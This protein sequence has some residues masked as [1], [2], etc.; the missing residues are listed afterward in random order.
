MMICQAGKEISTDHKC[1]HCGAEPGPNSH[2]RGEKKRTAWE[3]ERKELI[4]QLTQAR[5]EL[6]RYK[7]REATMGWADV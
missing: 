7:E 5:R 3:Q 6:A 2:C 4:E 1:H